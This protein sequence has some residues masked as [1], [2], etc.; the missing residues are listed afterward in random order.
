MVMLNVHVCPPKEMA[1]LAIPNDV[2][3]PD[4]LNE[5]FEFP[6]ANVPGCNVAVKP[7]TPVDAIEVPV[8]YATPLPP[9]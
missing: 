3:V 9:V 4:T 2:G 5:I 6:L 7:V 8:E 1:K